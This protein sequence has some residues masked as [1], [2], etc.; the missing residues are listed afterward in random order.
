MSEPLFRV[1]NLVTAFHTDEG[2]VRA[3]DDGQSD[4]DGDPLV[5]MDL[6]NGTITVEDF[7][8]DGQR[9]YRATLRIHS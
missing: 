5:D 4:H 8:P 6:Q 1:E 2:S 9:R 3:V 7:A